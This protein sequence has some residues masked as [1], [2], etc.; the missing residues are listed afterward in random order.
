MY[1]QR[2]ERDDQEN[3]NQAPATWNAVQPRNQATKRTI[4]KKIKNCGIGSSGVPRPSLADY[5]LLLGP[6]DGAAAARGG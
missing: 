3:V 1:G 6:T 5:V 2:D 4:K